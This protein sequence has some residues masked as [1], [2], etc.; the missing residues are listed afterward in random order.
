MN[1]RCLLQIPTSFTIY[2][3]NIDNT[4]YEKLVYSSLKK[5]INN[6]LKIKCPLLQVSNFV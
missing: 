3:N 1:S 4:N 5:E 6:K 2:F